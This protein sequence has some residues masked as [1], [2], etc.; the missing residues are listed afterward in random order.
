[1][2]GNVLVRSLNYFICSGWLLIAE[3]KSRL[4]PNNGGA[5]PV[6]FSEAIK[7]LGFSLVSQVCFSGI[8]IYYFQV[9]LFLVATPLI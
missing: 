9:S 3:V 2:L 1:M 4:D 6:E 5:D 7:D 8:V